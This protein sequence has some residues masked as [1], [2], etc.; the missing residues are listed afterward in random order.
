MRVSAINS[1][2][3][4]YYLYSSQTASL[5]SGLAGTGSTGGTSVASALGGTSAGSLSSL[6]SLMLLSSYAASQAAA[7]QDAY[8]TQVADFTAGV[9]DLAAGTGSLLALPAAADATRTAAAVD[10][11]VAGFN[12]LTRT[13]KEADNLT[14]AGR[15]LLG[16]LQAA[17]RVRE[18]DLKAIGIAYDN[19]SGQLT[20][21]ELKLKQAVAGDWAKVRETL[22]GT[23]GLGKA[24][25]K[26]V[27]TAAAAPVADYLAN[28][29]SALAGTYS[30]GRDAAGLS[31]Y[32]TA[33]SRGLM[34][35]LLV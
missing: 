32:Y 23:Y 30:P 4:Y 19:R 22:T 5:V 28:P 26:S 10:Q 20:V 15:G 24:V 34:L 7:L 17:V 25:E 27:S 6:Y 13:L 31:A 3:L 8:K 11:F 9:R 18:D 29:S 14:A 2:L 35:D 16:S 12:T 1:N 21:D 33:L